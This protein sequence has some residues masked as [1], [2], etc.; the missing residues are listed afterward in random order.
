[1]FNVL[2]ASKIT[3]NHHGDVAPYANNLRLYEATGVGTML[4]TDW[5]LNLHEMF[6][7]N[8][9]LVPYR[10][11]EECAAL[12]NHYLRHDD[13][14]EVIARAGQ[15]RTLRDHTSDQRMEELV[16]IIHRYL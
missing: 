5:K 12:V 6:H 8:R 3:M 1:M 10:T 9:E 2:Y 15:R 14:R 11:V 7:A 13:E 16:K 4:L